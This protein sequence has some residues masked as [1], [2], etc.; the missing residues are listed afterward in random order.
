MQFAVHCRR[1]GPALRI[2]IHLA[3]LGHV[4]KV[5]DHHI[6]RQFSLA[7]SFGDI[8]DLFLRRIDRLT[9]DVPIS[10]SRQHMG[11]SRQQTVTL[12]NF[13]AALPGD[14]EVRDA[15]SNL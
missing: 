11:D 2:Q 6:Q 12:I 1:I 5:D 3:L 15:V 10:G 13:V 14:Y 7:V 8:Q 9:L 4:E